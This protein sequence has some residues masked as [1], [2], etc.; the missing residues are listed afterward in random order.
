MKDIP[1]NVSNIHLNF[2]FI[3]FIV[4]GKITFEGG[5]LCQKCFFLDILG[6][7]EKYFR[8]FDTKKVV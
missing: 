1:S 6:G 8:I 7:T 5:L 3:V 4:I 2:K